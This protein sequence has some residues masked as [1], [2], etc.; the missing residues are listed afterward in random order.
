MFKVNANYTELQGSYLFSEIA[1]RVDEYSKTH[2]QEANNI[3]R[4]GIGDVTQ[5]LVPACVEALKKAAD[6]M[7][8][9][10]GFHGYGP[11]Q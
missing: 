2:P 8:T 11:E 5:P 6:E 10:E 4:L 7:S 9:R 1:R 3:I